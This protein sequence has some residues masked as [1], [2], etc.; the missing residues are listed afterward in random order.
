MNVRLTSVRL[1][2]PEG[3]PAAERRIVGRILAWHENRGTG[4]AGFLSCT[5]AT[6]ENAPWPGTG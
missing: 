2:C 6:Y 4:R 3:A 1:R 5:I